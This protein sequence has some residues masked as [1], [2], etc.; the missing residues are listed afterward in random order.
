MIQQKAK[1]LNS[2]LEAIP[3]LEDGFLPLITAP[4]LL[5]QLKWN[6]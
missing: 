5:D 4:I 6:L 1:G 2:R 3:Y